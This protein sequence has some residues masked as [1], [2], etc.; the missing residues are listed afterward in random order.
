MGKLSSSSVGKK[1][2]MRSVRLLYGHLV[3]YVIGV[4][5]PHV[6]GGCIK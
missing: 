3:D 5:S 4:Q 1:K 2:A 6:S